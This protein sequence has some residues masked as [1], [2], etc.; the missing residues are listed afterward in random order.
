MKLKLVAFLIAVCLLGLLNNCFVLA[1]EESVPF[2]GPK[3]DNYSET[4][5]RWGEVVSTDIQNKTLTIKYLDFETDQEKELLLAVDES[6]VYEN[7]KSLEEIQPKDILSVDFLV[8][9]SKNV[10]KNIS[11]EK[12]EGLSPVISPEVVKVVPS[13]VKSEVL[14]VVNSEAGKVISED[15]QPS[16]AA[17]NVAKTQAL[18]VQPEALPVVDQPKEVITVSQEN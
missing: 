17:E 8:S 13:D 4:K 7:V 6:T 12:P 11:I 1:E 5:W 18:T 9:D 16:V 3:A 10:A 2:E 15:P 14:P